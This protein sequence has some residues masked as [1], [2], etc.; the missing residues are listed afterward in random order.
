MAD[1]IVKAE[2]FAVLL[3]TAMVLARVGVVQVMPMLWVVVVGV[4]QIG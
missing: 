1:F 2:G 3:Q 4:Y